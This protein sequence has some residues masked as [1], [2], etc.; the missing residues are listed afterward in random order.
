M[1]LNKTLART[2]VGGRER[3]TLDVQ[4]AAPNSQLPA[5]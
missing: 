4:L 1:I 3:V 5:Q 2:H